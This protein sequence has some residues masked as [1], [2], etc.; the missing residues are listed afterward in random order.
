MLFRSDVYSASYSNSYYNMVYDDACDALEISIP[1]PEL[2]EACIVYDMLMKGFHATATTYWDILR[3]NI[4]YYLTAENK[5]IDI[6]R[7]ILNRVSVTYI[8]D[9]INTFVIRMFIKL[10]NMAHD[11]LKSRLSNQFILVLVLFI[12]FIVIVVLI[13]VIAWSKFMDSIRDS[14]WVTK[15]MLAIIPVNIMIKVPN[16]KNFLMNSSKSFIKSL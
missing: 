6:I 7:E 9:A 2:Y 16:I 1:E 10:L 14:I 13:Y 15:C 3:E 4:D 11:D 5:T 12:A 8:E